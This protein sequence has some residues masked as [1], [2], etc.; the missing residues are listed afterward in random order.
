MFGDFEMKGIWVPLEIWENKELT[1]QEKVIIIEVDSLDHGGGAYIQNEY[2]FEQFKISLKQ[3]TCT[4]NSLIEKNL[5][6]IY[7]GTEGQRLLK[8][9]FDLLK[10]G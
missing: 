10:R 3:T 4:I 5:L 6:F 1:I 7:L 8:V 2:F 9:N